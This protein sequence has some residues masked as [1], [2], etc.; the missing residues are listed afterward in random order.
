MRSWIR[1]PLLLAIPAAWSVLSQHDQLDFLEDHLLDLQFR[2][3]GARETPLKIAYVDIDNEAIQAYRWPWNHSRY[4]QLTDALFDHGKIKA[5]GFD[6]LFSENSRPDFGVDEQNEGRIQF[7]K[8]IHR[9]HNVVLAT[10]YVPGPGL[11]QETRKFPWIF[12]GATNPELN[13]T[14]ELPAFPIMGPT[15]GIPGMI[16]TYKREARL[17]PVFADTPIAT[18]YPMALRLAL[19]H[20]GLSEEGIQRH[21]DHMAICDADGKPKTRIP[22]EKGQLVEANWFSPWISP[23]NPRCSVADI[24]RNL[25]LLDEHDPA[26]REIGQEFFRQFNDAIVL[27]GAVDPLLQDLGTTPFD[28]TPVPQ[29]GFHGNLLKTIVSGQYI[30]RPSSWASH[31]LTFLLTL[32]TVLLFMIRGTNRLR[33]KFLAITLLCTYVLAAY[34]LFASHNLVLPLAGPLGSTATAGMLVL[35]SQLFEEQR[36]KQRIQSL[37]GTYVSPQ[38]VEQ[39]VETGETP[40]LGGL[41]TEITAYFSDIQGFSRISELLPANRLVELMNEYLSACTGVILEEQG[42]LD[43]YFGDAVIAMYGGLTPLGDHAYRACVASQRVLLRLEELK[44]KWMGESD[45][46]PALVGELR[47]RI[48]LNSGSAIIGNMGSPYRFNFTMMGDNVN[49]AARM[50][51]GARL[52]GVTTMATEATRLEC[53]RHGGEHVVFRKLDQIIVKG[54]NSP[55]VIHQIMGLREDLS[56]PALECI[57][58]FERGLERYFSMDW[59]GAESIFMKSADLEPEKPGMTPGVDTNPSLVMIRRCREMR[60]NPPPNGWNG[61]YTMTRK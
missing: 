55:V 13:D 49:L 44:R 32:T 51:S 28:K 29:V 57:D 53:V 54:R 18:F 7:G 9:H 59:A 60:T 31:T 17:A 4:A 23:H 20:W 12:E 24:G 26:R 5:I 33:W 27:V 30:R 10:N 15:W 58:R 36:S 2:I 19:I 22:L 3:R 16:D 48:G 6:V 50:E 21:P 56:D 34:F 42:A 61:V 1:Y 8:S 14:P 37:F 45:K 43:K 46:W 52:Y 39:M 38:L 35:G 11:L 47:S 25:T 40:Q 41:E